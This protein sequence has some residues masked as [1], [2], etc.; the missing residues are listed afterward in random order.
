MAFK[1]RHNRFELTKPI[2]N[3]SYF[4]MGVI[5][6]CCWMVNNKETIRGTADHWVISSTTFWRRI[7]K[8]CKDL[9]PDLYKAVC[10]QMAFNLKHHHRQKR[11]IGG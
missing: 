10:N 5:C 9:S 1:L 4:E 8:E 11:H 2:E 7:H 6:T 3:L